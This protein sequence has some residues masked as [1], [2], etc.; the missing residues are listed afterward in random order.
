MQAIMKTKQEKGFEI[1]E[2]KEPEIRYGTDV[3]LKIDIASICG[4]DHHMWV[5]D[6]WAQK[7]LKPPFIAGHEV[8]GTVLEVGSDVKN[9]EVGDRIKGNQIN[10]YLE[11]LKFLDKNEIKIDN[12]EIGSGDQVLV[13]VSQG[14][15]VVLSVQKDIEKQVGL[16]AVILQR[17]KVEGKELKR[18]DLR[19]DKP[20]VEY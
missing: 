11:I 15:E 13:Y 7:R 6:Q 10:T 4:T 19:F 9:I 17:Y 3:K 5:F 16:L 1:Q 14:P 8:G 18:V 20:V 12:L 2:V